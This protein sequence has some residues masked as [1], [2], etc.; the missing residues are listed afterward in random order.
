MK[1]YFFYLVL[2]S[3]IGWCCESI[4]VSFGQKKVVNSG[5]MTGPFCPI[6][7]FGAIFAIHLLT[8]LIDHPLLVFI[9]GIIVTSAL[10][11][12]T[13]WLMEMVLHVKWWD[14]SHHKYHIN[15][16]VCLTNSILFGI[17]ALVLLY[18]V[19]PHIA[20][21][22]E[23][24]PQRI[25]TIVDIV[26][27]VYLVSD[28][29]A[30]LAQFVSFKQEL[31]KFEASVREV[32]ENIAENSDFDVQDK[33]NALLESGDTRMQELK[34]RLNDRYAQFREN[35]RFSVR[36]MRNAFTNMRISPKHEMK[37]VFTTMREKYEDKNK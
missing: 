19:H 5:F 17:M 34:N 36:R 23:G 10:E 1:E 24:W 21:W 35:R 8:P 27:A 13:S 37:N 7:G 4:F 31:A 6:Y 3:F 2:Y 9:F 20:A 22:V 18:G 15:G 33:F 28:F 12:F 30:S 26:L 25:L 16:R 32:L 29:S 14:Y 11:Y